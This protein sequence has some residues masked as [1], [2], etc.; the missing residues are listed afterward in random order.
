MFFVF[1]RKKISSYLISLG[2]VVILFAA[3]FIVTSKANNTLETATKIEEKQKN[4]FE[5]ENKGVASSINSNE[6]AEN[7]ECNCN[8]SCNYNCNC[9]CNMH[10]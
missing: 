10:Q 4:N 7:I 5:T 9:N 1:D 8:C 3:S 6:N 2:T